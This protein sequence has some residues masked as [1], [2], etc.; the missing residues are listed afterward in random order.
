[1]TMTKWHIAARIAPVLSM[2]AVNLMLIHQLH[3]EREFSHR[4]LQADEQLLQA[5]KQL[6]FIN[7]QLVKKLASVLN[8]CNVTDNQRGQ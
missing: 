6:K 4:L 5:D 8:E 1:M 2:L 7:E 3:H